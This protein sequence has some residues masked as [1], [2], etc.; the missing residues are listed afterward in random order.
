M[1]EAS[2]TATTEF[3]GKLASLS[4]SLAE[5]DIWSPERERDLAK[6]AQHCEWP[7]QLGAAFTYTHA[8]CFLCSELRQLA[9][10]WRVLACP[11]VPR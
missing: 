6:I 2:L 3:I 10:V 1:A 5:K 7:G 11:A 8:V 9:G 4:L